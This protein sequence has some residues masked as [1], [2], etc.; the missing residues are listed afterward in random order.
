MPTFTMTHEIDCDAERFW[1]L[2]FDRELN[3]RV[4]ERLGFP[5]W[6]V[7]EQRETDAEIVRVV[8]VTPKLDMPRAVAKALGS[9]VGYVER[10]RFDRAAGKFAFEME[11]STLKDKIHNRGS[12]RTE[13]RGEKRIARITEIHIEAKVFGL[14]GMIESMM[15]KNTR[16]AWG[17]S[18]AYMN[19][20][21]KEHS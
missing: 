11:P 4:F 19:E 14:G 8:E 17:K 2:F 18:A 15:E 5:K 6:H 13:P 1:K 7:V 10:G 21:L 3:E 16:D 20:W 9:G 12:V